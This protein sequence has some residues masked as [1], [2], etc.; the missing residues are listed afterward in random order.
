M[1]R[2]PCHSGLDVFVRALP[3]APDE[4]TDY[5]KESYDPRS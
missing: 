2:R 3:I 4:L 5:A 1:D